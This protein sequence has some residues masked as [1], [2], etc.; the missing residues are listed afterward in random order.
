[1]RCV[2]TLFTTK[3]HNFTGWLVEL[4]TSN[5]EGAPSTQ[6]SESIG[7]YLKP[8]I[9][10]QGDKTSYALAVVNKNLLEVKKVEFALKSL[11]IPSDRLY[12]V[13]DLWTSEDHGAVDSSYVFKF[14]LRPT[15]AV[16][17]KLT[18]T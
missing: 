3:V 13:W 2:A 4:T 17:L 7:V 11:S 16:M 10:V 5:G 18:L 14:E 15:S 6:K 8:I 1:R 9:P 12:H